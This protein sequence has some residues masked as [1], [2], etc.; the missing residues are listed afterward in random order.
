MFSFFFPRC[1]ESREPETHF[2]SGDSLRRNGRRDSSQVLSEEW[3]MED[4]AT[5]T[6][7]VAVALRV[8]ILYSFVSFKL[9]DV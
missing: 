1:L 5:G 2:V 3:L 7:C 4:R 9:E 8:A 6:D